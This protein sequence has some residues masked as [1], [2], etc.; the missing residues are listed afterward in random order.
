MHCDD[1]CLTC[2]KD[3]TNCTDCDDGFVLQSGKCVKV[4][5]VLSNCIQA[6]DTTDPTQGC[7]ACRGGFYESSGKCNKCVDNCKICT[8]SSITDCQL[9]FNGYR[10]DS[11]KGVLEKCNGT[12][13]EMCV[14]SINN[15]SVC[16]E[17]FYPSSDGKNCVKG[18]IANCKI[19]SST[20]SSCSEC[21]ASYGVSPDGQQCSPCLEGCKGECT[22]SV[23]ESGECMQGYYFNSDETCVQCPYW[24]ASCYMTSDKTVA[25]GRCS[26]GEAFAISSIMGLSC[27]KTSP[28][29]SKGVNNII[30][31]ISLLGIII[32]A[33]IITTPFLIK[34]ARKRGMMHY[35]V[36]TKHHGSESH[37][38]MLLEEHE[39]L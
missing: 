19:Y 5:T 29:F 35:R 8:G 13:C 6:K 38:E 12:D 25:C 33:F 27:D 28:K 17:G 15:C 31:I 9:G 26:S 11:N 14:S 34:L 21:L 30:V 36:N 1:N 23:C 20:G 24:C 3:A 16:K 22:E 4:D 18:K 32:L 37:D 7:L 10:Y 2:E 39:L